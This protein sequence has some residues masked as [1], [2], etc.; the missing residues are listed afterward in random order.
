MEGVE[1]MDARLGTLQRPVVL[2]RPVRPEC[3]AT[4]PP[5]APTPS[6]APFDP[7]RRWAIPVTRLW[8]GRH[9]RH[10]HA[11]R[12]ERTALAGRRY[13]ASG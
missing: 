12:F 6:D 9:G 1:V 10:P 13:L 11:P 3:V 2:R 4:A 8:A 7:T 5:E